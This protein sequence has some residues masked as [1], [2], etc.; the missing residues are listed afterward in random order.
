MLTV[1]QPAECWNVSVRL[2]CQ[3][4]AHK[5]REMEQTDKHARNAVCLAGLLM[6]SLM[7]AVAKL[8]GRN[9]LRNDSRAT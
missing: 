6:S 4:V 2:I 1:A 7:F 5:T 8:P 3:L 9:S